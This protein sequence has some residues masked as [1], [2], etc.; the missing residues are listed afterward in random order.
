MNNQQINETPSFMK[1]YKSY[2]VGEEFDSYR[3]YKIPCMFDIPTVSQKN[4]SFDEFV[5][6]NDSNREH[7]I[8]LIRQMFEDIVV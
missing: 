5:D 6:K 8:H 4:Y 2:L 1:T 3:S 7:S